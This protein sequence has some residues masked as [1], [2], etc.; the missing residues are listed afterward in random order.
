MAKVIIGIHGLGNK[1]GKEILS[2]WWRSAMK[3][4]LRATGFS[5]RMPAFT[6]VYWADLIYPRALDPGITDPENDLFNDEPYA[7]APENFHGGSHSVRVKIIDFIGRQLNRLFLNDDLTLNYT[8]ITDNIIRTYFKDLEFYYTA[9][10]EKADG[11]RASAKE[12]IRSRLAEVL[13]LHRNDEIMLIAHSMGSIIAY[14]TLILSGSG[15]KVDT[16]ITIGSPL[17]MPVVISKIAGELKIRAQGVNR[18]RTPGCVTH[19]WYNLSDILD[20]VAFNFK[21]ADDFAENDN[22]V[23]PLDFLVTNDYIFDG[24]PNPHKSF[25]YLRA[26]EFSDVLAGFISRRRVTVAD[27]ILNKTS[28]F[29]RKIFRHDKP[30]HN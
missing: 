17:G 14:D 9:S 18:L 29:I 23:R 8:S 19:A 24:I 26:R 20:K 27:R 3:E 21:L 2:D 1:P 12:L 15:I 22:G 30:S 4:G 28:Q 13:K 11:T 10:V 25:G 5:G 7:S 6:L 16:L